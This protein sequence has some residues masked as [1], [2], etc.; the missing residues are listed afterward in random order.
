MNKQERIQ[1]Y[2]NQKEKLSLDNLKYLGQL[3]ALTDFW[4]QEDLG[5]EGDITSNLMI[6]DNMEATAEIVAKE[7]G[8][9]AGI[10]EVKWL[11][12]AIVVESVNDGSVVKKGDVLCKLQAPIKDILKL[13]RTIL[14]LLQRMSGIATQTANLFKET[15]GKVLV[16][17]T[18]KTQWGLLDKKAVTVGGGGTHRLGLYDFI[19]IK[20]NHLKASSDFQPPESFWEIEVES[21][22]QARQMAKLNPGAMMFDDFTPDDIKKAIQQI[23]GG[24]IFEASGGIDQNNIQDYIN[25]GVD[26]ISL[27]SLTHSTKA[28]DIGLYISNP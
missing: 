16:C 22:E 26:I 24:I 1:K 15:K 19:L 21:I 4:L 2:F 27:G 23:D 7:D 11:C 25:T 12:G 6:K 17:P 13:E 3:K 10:E 14:N 20:E 9:V 18:R 8:V 5:E 28:L